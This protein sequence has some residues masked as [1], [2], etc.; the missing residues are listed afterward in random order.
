[1]SLWWDL[2]FLLLKRFFL[3]LGILKYWFHVHRFFYFVL[4]KS[5]LSLVKLLILEL[6]ICTFVHVYFCWYS[7]SFCPPVFSSIL[8][9]FREFKM[10]ILNSVLFVNCLSLRIVTV[11]LLLWIDRMFL[12]ITSEAECVED[13]G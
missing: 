8:S 1:M 6:N 7:F 11:L 5:R 12:Y 10:V 4:F 3:R 9:V 2:F 13:E